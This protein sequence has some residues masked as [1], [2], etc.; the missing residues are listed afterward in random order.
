MWSALPGIPVGLAR[1]RAQPA[2][3]PRATEHAARAEHQPH[4]HWNALPLEA[5]AANAGPHESTCSRLAPTRPLRP[6]RL[7]RLAGPDRRPWPTEAGHRGPAGRSGGGRAPRAGRAAGPRRVVLRSRRPWPG[8]TGMRRGGARRRHV[9]ARMRGGARAPAARLAAERHVAGVA[10]ARD[11][12]PARVA[13]P[14]PRQSATCSPGSG[15]A[16]WRGPDAAVGIDADEGALPV[17]PVEAGIVGPDS[18]L[19]AAATSVPTACPTPPASCSSRGSRA[20]TGCRAGRRGGATWVKAVARVRRVPARRGRP[21]GRR[22]A[23]AS[24]SPGGSFAS[25]PGARARPARRRGWGRARCTVAAS[26]S[27]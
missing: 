7:A 25:P 19:S 26:R 27:P 18:R 5:A 20:S 21:G 17:V 15:R 3:K 9:A 13:H 8:Q 23:P 2:D 4:L 11:A 14:R 1:E 12:H 6:S 16:S 24:S 10:A 22:P